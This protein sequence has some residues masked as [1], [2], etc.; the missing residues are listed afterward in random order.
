MKKFIYIDGSAGISGDMFLA[1]LIDLGFSFDKFKQE[2]HKLKLPVKL[3]IRETRRLSLRALKVN[4]RVEK[5]GSQ[6]RKWED[7]QQIILESPFASSVKNKSLRIFKNLFQAE[8]RVHGCSFEEAHLHEAGADDALVDI[9]GCSLLL[10]GLKTEKI[11]A[12]PLNIG[13]GWVKTSH[14][15]LPVPPPAVA[16]LLKGI[17]VYSAWAEA[18]LVTPTGA[19][20]A[21]TL[22]D[23]FV[24]FPQLCYQKIGCGAG[25]KDFPDFPN[26]LRLFYG[27]EES[28]NQE[29]QIFLLETNIDDSSPQ[30]LAAFQEKALSLGALDVY[31]TPVVMKKNRL[32]SKLTILT[33]A[34]KIEILIRELF[35]ETSSIGVR[36]FPVCRRILDRTFLEIEIYGEKVKM[37]KAFLEE[38]EI[39]V[40]PELSDCLRISRKKNIPLPTVLKKANE[41]YFRK[42]NKEEGLP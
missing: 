7:I 9:V 39:N 2:I 5:G 16:E 22:I 13:R 15:N 20:I 21:S 23:K 11:Y 34:D 37:K 30:V 1:A 10:E 41:A 12:S 29:E 14:G 17:P 36:Y 6:P 27:K 38:K 3:S 26:I 24:Q 35:K 32:A 31:L 42:N 8:S 4:V 28:F 33:G 40:Q 18:E 19:A 25:E